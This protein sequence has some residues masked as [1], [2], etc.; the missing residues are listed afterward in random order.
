MDAQQIM[1]LSHFH[2]SQP[3]C[4]RQWRQTL[5]EGQLDIA[6][7]V[8]DGD[9]RQ[10]HRGVHLEV[11]GAPRRGG[12]DFHQSLLGIEEGTWGAGAE[13]PCGENATVSS[14]A[15]LTRFLI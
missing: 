4:I 2:M 5:V 8:V 7:E 10:S 11:A 14:V 3:G 9:N 15:T 12:G 13:P 6:P 1:G